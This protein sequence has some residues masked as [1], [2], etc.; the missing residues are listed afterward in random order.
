VDRCSTL[1]HLDSHV[2]LR[3]RYGDLAEPRAVGTDTNARAFPQANS[4]VADM[5]TISVRTNIGLVRSGL[6]VDPDMTICHG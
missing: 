3:F 5:P 1:L 4:M 2:V 6:M